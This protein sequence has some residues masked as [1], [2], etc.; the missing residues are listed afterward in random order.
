[1]LA[2][3]L[4]AL[5]DSQFTHWHYTLKCSQL[6]WQTMPDYFPKDTARILKLFKANY[7]EEKGLKGSCRKSFL[8]C[9]DDTNLGVWY[10]FGPVSVV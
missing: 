9:N 2:W 10:P 4:V 1:M 6:C 8:P 5:V 7:E 3:Q